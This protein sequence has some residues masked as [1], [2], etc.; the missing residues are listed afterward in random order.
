MNNI[1]TLGKGRCH[2]RVNVDAAIE[3]NNHVTIV[4]FELGVCTR[5]DNCIHRQCF[6]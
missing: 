2:V 6:R 3:K 4:A 1:P 5:V